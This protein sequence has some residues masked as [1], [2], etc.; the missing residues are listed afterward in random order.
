MVKR[1]LGVILVLILISGGTIFALDQLNAKQDLAE[2]KRIEQ[3]KEEY[4][5]LE[6]LAKAEV[7]N[8]G[9]K[10]EAE[11]E[12]KKDQGTFKKEWRGQD[13]LTYKMDAVRSEKGTYTGTLLG[14]NMYDNFIEYNFEFE[15][16]TERGFL[17]LL[18]K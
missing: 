4:L 11:E 14:Y 8:K 16:M 17:D 12:Q 10:T 2:E 9:E 1:V 3:E 13:G 15:N 18:K 7:E 6:E 5:K